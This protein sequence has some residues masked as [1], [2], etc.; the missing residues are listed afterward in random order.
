MAAPR[1]K[2]L[3]AALV[4][5]VAAVL[6]KYGIR[7]PMPFSVFSLYMAVTLMAVLVYVSS[8]SD[9]WRAFVTPIW[10]T[11][12]EPGRR[13]LRLVLG[14]GIPLLVGYYA[15]SQASARAEAPLELCAV[16]P[17]PPGTV[18]SRTPSMTRLTTV[19][20]V[21]PLVPLATGNTVS[22][23]LGSWWARSAKP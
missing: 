8:D 15:Y 1:G 14:I 11:L 10:R 12:T 9:S 17:A 22:T 21:R 7:P 20:A 4:L 2:F 23:V 3:Q 5:I 18:T 13:P 6:F 16:H 19:A